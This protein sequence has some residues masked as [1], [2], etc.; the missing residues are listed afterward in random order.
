[1]RRARIAALLLLALPLAGCADTSPPGDVQVEDCDAEDYANRESECG[2][3]QQRTPATT[4]VGKQVR[5]QVDAKPKPSVKPK[6]N[7]SKS[8]K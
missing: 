5:T 3:V 2:F 4:R 1:M 8:R 6:S 7:V